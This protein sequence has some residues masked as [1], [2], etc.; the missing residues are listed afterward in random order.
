MN[1][2]LSP[3]SPHNIIN[4][5]R[6]NNL[7]RDINNLFFKHKPVLEFTEEEKNKGKEFLKNIGLNDQ[8]KFVCLAV[9]DSEFLQ[10]FNPMA[11]YEYHDYRDG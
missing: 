7:S 2:L 11:S 5:G 4:D 1:N 10:S 6:K 3:I 9:R 8:L